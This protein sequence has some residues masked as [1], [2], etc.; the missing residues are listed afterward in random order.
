MEVSDNKDEN[1]NHPVANIELHRRRSIESDDGLQQRYMMENR[2]D[3]ACPVSDNEASNNALDDLDD[4]QSKHVQAPQHNDDVNN[5]TTTH[6]DHLIEEA[7]K[8]H[9]SLHQWIDLLTNFSFYGRFMTLVLNI[10]LLVLSVFYCIGQTL[11]TKLYLVKQHLV[12]RDRL[13]DGF[14]TGYKCYFYKQ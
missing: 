13:R 4:F 14:L 9:L 2:G 12:G 8:S 11:E 5:T 3:L 7:D 10:V 1:Q 6:I